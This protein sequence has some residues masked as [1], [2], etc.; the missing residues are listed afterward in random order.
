MFFRPIVL[1]L[2][3][4]DKYGFKWSPIHDVLSL[5]RG[6]YL[7]CF[8]FYVKLNIKMWKRDGVYE[9]MYRKYI[10]IMVMMGISALDHFIAQPSGKRKW[11]ILIYLLVPFMWYL[12]KRTPW[13]WTGIALLLPISYC[14]Y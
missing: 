2:E 11:L 9:R 10:G 5:L 1:K 8:C 6:I 4:K 13:W 12:Q 14:Y 3:A 7:L